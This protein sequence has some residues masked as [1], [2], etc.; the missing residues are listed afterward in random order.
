MGGGVKIDGSGSGEGQ[1][2]GC[3]GH[4]DEL[5]LSIQCWEFGDLLI[6]HQLII[7]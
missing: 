5:P 7:K 3:C 4:G 6:N 1:V 2:V